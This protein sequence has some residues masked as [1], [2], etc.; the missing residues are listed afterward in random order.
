MSFVCKD[1]EHYHK[2]L[3]RCLLSEEEKEKL[4]SDAEYLNAK[5]MELDDAYY[6]ED[7]EY[8][9]QF[10]IWLEI[11]WTIQNYFCWDDQRGH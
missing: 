10:G 6:V 11:R 1:I 5:D 2:F 3:M 7:S 9:T 4:L 8:Q